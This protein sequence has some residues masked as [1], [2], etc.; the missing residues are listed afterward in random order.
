MVDATIIGNAL[1]WFEKNQSPPTDAKGWRRARNEWLRLQG[2][3]GVVK[4]GKNSKSIPEWWGS[5][6]SFW[7]TEEKDEKEFIKRFSN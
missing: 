5:C 7:F 3:G 4:N 6:T 2:V 1:S